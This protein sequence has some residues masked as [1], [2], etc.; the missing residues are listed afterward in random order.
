M[1]SR[2]FITRSLR[3]PTRAACPALLREN[4]ESI[5]VLG[6]EEEERNGV[7]GTFASVLRNWQDVCTQMLR[8]TT[9]S[10]TSSFIA[11]ILPI[12]LCAPKFLDG[13]MTLGQV[14]QAASAFITV[15]TAFNWLVDNYPRFADWSASAV[16]VASLM[17]SLDG[18]ERAES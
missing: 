14:M 10:Q 5:A 18:L 6:G 3:R 2:C 1:N 16:R 4:G 12:I 15:Q 11:P 8:T 17:A 9:V 13:S 7:D